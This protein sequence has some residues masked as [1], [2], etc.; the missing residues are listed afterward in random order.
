MFTLVFGTSPFQGWGSRRPS[1]G[2]GAREARQG[3]NTSPM[4][5]IDGYLVSAALEVRLMLYRS[6]MVTIPSGLG[7]SPA[8]GRERRRALAARMDYCVADIFFLL[9]EIVKDNILSFLLKS[10]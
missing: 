9:C 2:A 3:G 1:R 7:T 4:L 10:L 8:P 6:T 5:T